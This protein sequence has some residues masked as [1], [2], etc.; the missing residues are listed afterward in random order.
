[1]NLAGMTKPPVNT[2]N[3]VMNHYVK[4]LGDSAV[5]TCVASDTFCP[6]S[7]VFCWLFL[8]VLL[9]FPI[10]CY[11]HLDVGPWVL[12]S[13]GVL[14]SSP[15]L[16]FFSFRLF[17]LP[18]FLL[19][20]LLFFQKNTCFVFLCDIGNLCGFGIVV[21]CRVCLFGFVFFSSLPLLNPFFSLFLF[22]LCTGNFFFLFSYNISICYC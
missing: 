10:I 14:A 20:L 16:P 21:L 4:A 11:L 17:P 22:I 1:M 9:L 6:L 13:A 19:F 3:Y 15:P 8:P 18:F 7:L 2:L 5:L 12:F